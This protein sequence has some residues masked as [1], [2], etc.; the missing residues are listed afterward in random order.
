MVSGIHGVIDVVTWDL[1]FNNEKQ[2]PLCWRQSM[3]NKLCIK[4]SHVFFYGVCWAVKICHCLNG[5]FLQLLRALAHTLKKKC[6]GL[7]LCHNLFV[8]VGD[9]T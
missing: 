1:I 7:C 6:R 2:S 3:P 5:Y 4:V 8:L 9:I